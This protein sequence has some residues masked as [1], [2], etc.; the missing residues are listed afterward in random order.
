MCARSKPLDSCEKPVSRHYRY[1]WRTMPAG[2]QK[3][4]GFQGTGNALQLMCRCVNSPPGSVR[5]EQRDVMA[6]V[7]R[8]RRSWLTLRLSATTGRSQLC[9]ATPRSGGGA[10]LETGTRDRAREM[11]TGRQWDVYK[12]NQSWYPWIRE[13]KVLRGFE[14]KARSRKGPSKEVWGAKPHIS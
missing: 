11:G 12:L 2:I 5:T 9:P 1:C 6:S 10:C 8:W 7:R 13:H 4:V 14:Q 3:G